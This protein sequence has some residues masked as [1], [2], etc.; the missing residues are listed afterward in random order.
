[1]GEWSQR[2]ARAPLCVQLRLDHPAHGALVV[3]TWGVSDGEVLVNLDKAEGALQLGE[4]MTGQV[5][6][7]P[8]AAPLIWLEVLRFEEGGAILGF[9]PEPD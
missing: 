8:I 6:G 9:L 3:Q 2:N 5:Q 4:R 7:L 1:M